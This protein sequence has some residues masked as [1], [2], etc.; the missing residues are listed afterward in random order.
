MVKGMRILKGTSLLAGKIIS[1]DTELMKYLDTLYWQNEKPY[2]KDLTLA[3]GLYVLADPF[4]LQ[5]VES[6]DYSFTNF[7]IQIISVENDTVKF[8]E[9]TKPR[10]TLA[11][12]KKPLLDMAKRKWFI[13]P[14]SEADIIRER[15][16]KPEYIERHKRVKKIKN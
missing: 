10:A 14:D 16:N 1:T 4:Y 6:Y 9:D 5:K 8:L 15:Y 3:V 12:R 2:I 7:P 11:V 13:V